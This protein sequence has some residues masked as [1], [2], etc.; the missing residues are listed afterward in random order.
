MAL[1]STD[2]KYLYYDKDPES[3]ANSLHRMPVEGARRLK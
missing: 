2:G 3:D 1:E